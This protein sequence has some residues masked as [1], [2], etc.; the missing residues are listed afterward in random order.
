MKAFKIITSLVLLAIISGLASC[1]SAQITSSKSQQDF[2]IKSIALMPNG[3]ILADAVGTELLN[4]GYNVIDATTVSSIMIRNNIEEVEIT[5][6]KNLSVFAEMEIDALLVLRAVAGYDDKPQSATF[7][8]L[9]TKSG[10]IIAGGTWQN[11]KGGAVGSPADGMMRS[12]AVK[13]AKQIAD[14]LGKLLTK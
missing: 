7:R 2:N 6:P 10:A 8:L 13:A 12:D 3:G 9:D 11:G 5:L 4:Y 14:E 1:M